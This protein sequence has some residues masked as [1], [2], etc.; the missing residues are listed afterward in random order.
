MNGV[1]QLIE[2]LDVVLARKGLF[3]LKKMDSHVFSSLF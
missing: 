3:Q 1:I 2:V